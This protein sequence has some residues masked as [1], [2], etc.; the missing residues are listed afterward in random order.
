MRVHYTLTLVKVVMHGRHWDLLEIRWDEPRI[1]NAPYAIPLA[2]AATREY[3][4]RIIPGISALEDAHL[5][6][7]F[8]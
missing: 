4:L 5:E 6:I 1:P 3:V 2:W 7:A 8:P